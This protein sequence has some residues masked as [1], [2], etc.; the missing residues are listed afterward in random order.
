MNILSLFDGIS[1][2]RV[3]LERANI[4]VDKYFSSEIDKYAIQVSTKNW[5]D[6][7][8]LGDV[9]NITKESMRQQ[10]ISEIDLI[11]GGFPCQSY[12]ISGNRQ[13]LDDDRGKLVF[14]C[15]RLVDELKPKF[16][17]FE[18]VNSMSKE[19]K[20]FIDNLFGIGHIM[21]NASLVSAQNRKRIFWVGKRV[22][23]KYEQVKIGQPEDKNIFLK[24]IIHETKN[25]DFDLQ[26]YIVNGNHLKWITDFNRLKKK[27]TQINE[28]K[29]ITMTA[30][31][32]ANW[33]GQYLSIRV[34]QFNNGGQGDR[35]Y[36]TEGKS[37]N[38]SANG[39]GRGAKTGIYLI[40]NKNYGKLDDR[41][42]E[43]EKGF[44]ESERNLLNMQQRKEN[45]DTSYRRELA[46][47]QS[48][49]FTGSLSGLSYN[50]SQEKT[51]VQSRRVQ[52][53][54][55]KEWL[56]RQAQSKIQKNRES[57]NWGEGKYIR[58]LTPIEAERL[59]SLDDNYTEGISNSQ[60]YKCCGNAFNAEVVKHILSFIK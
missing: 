9:K 15:K 13:G 11:V 35:I 21:I 59:Q 50:N 39:G 54:S 58:K 1:V 7:I 45:R 24:D 16:F 20:K 30:R 56:L 49:E 37:V 40:N 17:I 43:S 4:K 27:Y 25:E 47:Q 31:Q 48:T 23:D 36:S 14:E 12:S 5:P 46:Q 55:S 38:L 53:T 51:I 10:G 2:A 29:A 6:I 18:N 57:I 34:G 42:L 41:T 26:K 60:R 32:Y 22:G 28:D 19:N 52:S 44:Q 33:N 3:A 8:Q